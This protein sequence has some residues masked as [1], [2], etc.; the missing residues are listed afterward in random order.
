MGGCLRLDHSPCR[1]IRSRGILLC[2]A[3]RSGGSFVQQEFS[4]AYAAAIQAGPRH[5]PSL[6][7]RALAN[8]GAGAYLCT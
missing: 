1:R 3:I 4:D 6:R 2:S 5:K 7:E 8:N